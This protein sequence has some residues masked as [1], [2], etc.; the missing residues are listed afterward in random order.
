[1]HISPNNYHTLQPSLEH[2]YSSYTNRV[3]RSWHRNL[4]LEQCN[5]IQSYH[6]RWLYPSSTL[7]RNV[8]AIFWSHLITPL[9]RSIASTFWLWL[10]LHL[11]QVGS[12]S[13]VQQSFI[14][15]TFPLQQVFCYHYYS[16]F[17]L[18]GKRVFPLFTFFPS[19]LSKIP[20]TIN[21]SQTLLWLVK[22]KYMFS[23]RK[24]RNQYCEFL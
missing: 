9:A 4:C 21:L 7:Y 8:F 15:Q 17:S 19:L 2:G 16:L 23:K 14:S 12:A 3:I 6:T 24:T 10:H 13:N 20:N 5:R 11:S 1:M 18:H 22:A